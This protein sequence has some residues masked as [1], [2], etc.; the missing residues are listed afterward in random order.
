MDKNTRETMNEMMENARKFLEEID[1][2]GKKKNSFSV[3]D[4]MKM[5]SKSGFED[6]SKGTGSHT[7][8]RHVVEPSIFINLTLDGNINN[9]TLPGYVNSVKMALENVVDKLSNNLDQSRGR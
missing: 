8:Y 6:V 2:V 4:L 7:R 1:S 3:K 5:L 9:K